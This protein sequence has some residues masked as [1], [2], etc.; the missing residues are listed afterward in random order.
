MRTRLISFFVATILVVGAYATT[1]LATDARGFTG[2]T[3]A[4]GRFE[5]IDLKAHTLPASF[6]QARLKTLGFSDLYV[7]SNVWL[8]GGSSGWHTHPGPSLIIVTVGFVT[9]YDGDDPSCTPHVYGVGSLLGN[10]LVD[11][12]DGQVHVIRNETASEA[13]SITVQLIPALAARRINAPASLNCP[14][15]VD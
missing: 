10:T 12:G 14:V 9:T 4:T 6:W 1:L 5:E 2:T 8:A 7:Q 15:S 13:R 11:P 3:L